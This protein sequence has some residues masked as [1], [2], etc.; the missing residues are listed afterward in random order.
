MK[1]MIYRDQLQGNYKVIR[2]GLGT[3]I[4]ELLQLKPAGFN[5]HKP[6]DSTL[7]A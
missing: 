5:Y 6:F 4:V 3:Y 2:I 7:D 1:C